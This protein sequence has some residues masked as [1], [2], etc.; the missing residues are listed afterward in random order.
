MTTPTTGTTSV[1]LVGLGNMGFAIAQRLTLAGSLVA[2]DLDPAKR[3]AAAELGATVTDGLATFADCNIVVLSLPAPAISRAVVTELR[4]ILPESATIVETSTVNPHDMA[5]LRRIL[6]GSGI[7]IVDAAVLSG[8][9]VMAKGA[10]I[11]LTGGDEA[12]LAR[13]QPVLESMSARILPFGPSGAGMSAKVINNAV[14]HAVMVVL[15]EAAALAEVTGV[16]LEA[17]SELLMDPDA[18]LTRPLTHRIME[19]VANAD[20][21]GG[22]PLDAARKDSTLVLELAQKHQVPLFGIQAAHTAY[23]LAMAE[24][25]ARKDYAAI[26]TLWKALD[27][28]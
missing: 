15:C 13:V 17:I 5:D 28:E 27:R 4:G 16:S 25:L 8:V 22:M 10:A 19:R 12:D 24:G 20:Y 7:G 23:E 3:D 21:E 6:D 11:L 18:G 2:F 9:G 14:A 26:A 1:G